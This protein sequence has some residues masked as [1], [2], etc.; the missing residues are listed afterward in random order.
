MQLG[1]TLVTAA[2]SASFLA[3]SA[4][5]VV[6]S[7]TMTDTSATGLD[8]FIATDDIIAGQLGTEL[9]ANGWHPANT[10]P[11]DQGPALTDG[12]GLRA[13]NALSGLLNDFPGAGN[14]AKII[15]YTFDTTNVG[16]IQIL[17]GNEGQ[18]GRVFS[19]TVVEYSKD[20]GQNYEQLG[21]FESDLPGTLNNDSVDPRRGATLVTIFDDAST[22]LLAGINAIKFSF[23]AVDNTGGQYRDPFDGVNPFTGIDDG[24]TAAFVS[25]LIYEVDVLVPEPASIGM[26]AALGLL[27]LRRR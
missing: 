10:N 12:V 7:T 4:F 1:R 8:S 15:E 16:S 5:G 25:P 26:L 2:V 27:A 13:P 14:P 18:D 17:S 3:V 22:T 20:G 23:Y 24:L 19:T 21:Y 6:T 11:L 9:D